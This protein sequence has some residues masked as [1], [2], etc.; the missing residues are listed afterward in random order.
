[1]GN[2]LKILTINCCLID[3]K[4]NSKI[5]Y[6]LFLL[7]LIFNNC[8]AGKVVFLHGTGSAGKTSLCREILQQSDEWKLVGEDDIYFK[9][10]ARYWKDEFFEEYKA[11]EEAID[12]ENILH[13]VMRN[14]I[15]FSNKAS[16]SARMKAKHAISIIQDQLNSRSKGQ[17]GDNQNSWHNKLRRQ[18][19]ETIID[20]AKNNNVIV[21]TWF[22]KDEHI[23]L[24]SKQ[25]DV[26]HV[27]AY[28][29]FLDII[30]RTIK[31]NYDAL[32][33]GEI[34]SNLRFFHQALNSF[35]GLYDLSSRQDGSI[36]ELNKEDAVHGCDLVW[37]CLDDS[38]NATGA[39]KP[40]TRGEF[41]LQEF[42]EYQQALLAKFKKEKVYIH[43]KRKI[44]AII[45]TNQKT[46]LECAKEVVALVK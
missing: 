19:T 13:A 44:D 1:M 45:R 32:M 38:S 39:I 24:I 27:A 37:L 15:L 36:D 8:F 4:K 46:A 7:F 16:Y 28:C 40:F 30:K 22:L 17:E 12:A 26:L 21:D 25:Y 10:V 23:D 3:V 29:P 9:E 31:R 35:T 42:D 5:Y 2:Y 14:Q 20:L 18:I 11:I 43:P 33:D 41:S 34:I 6:F